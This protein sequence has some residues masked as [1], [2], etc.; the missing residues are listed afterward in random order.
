MIGH[1]A[2]DRNIVDGQ[3]EIAT[4]GGVYFGSMVLRRLGLDVA[5]VTRL[6][7]GDFGLLDEMKEA[8]V[9]VFAT[10]APETSGIAN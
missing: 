9:Q 2:K 10:A 8:G 3:G 6:H 7:P 4:G 1:L 5:V